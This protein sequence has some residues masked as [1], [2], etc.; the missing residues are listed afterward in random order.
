LHTAA[1]KKP[2]I[3]V[4]AD[5]LLPPHGTFI[6]CQAEALEGFI[7]YY[8]GPRQLVN[9]GLSLPAERVLAINAA[10]GIIGKIRETPFR[11]FG[12]APIY[13][14]RLRSLNPVLL[15]AHFG[16]AGL[17]ALCLAE[18]L[19]IPLVTTFHGFD[20]TIED[21][22]LT[23]SVFKQARYV[24]RRHILGRRGRLFL[25]VSQFI[26]RKMLERGFSEKKIVVHYTG[27]DTDFF[28][29]DQVV[30][31]EP[32]VL[33]TG[34]LNQQKGCEYLI[35]AMARV[36]AAMPD[37]ELVVIGEGP[38]RQRLEA[39]AREKLTRFRFLGTQNPNTVRH[40]MNRAKVFSVPSVAAES[41]AEEGFGMVF[42][43][44]QAMGCP[45][46][47]F[48]TGGIPEAVAHEQ[49]GL[50]AKERDAETLSE[51]ILLLLGNEALWRQMSAA[52]RNRVCALFDLK[53]QTKRLEDIYDQVTNQGQGSPP[54]LSASYAL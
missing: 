6:R 42:A 52:G 35:Q 5:P 34:S 30:E 12:Y 47:S 3:L 4:F 13:F 21:G 49:T 48:S 40:W 25:A 46:V 1:K 24:R 27:V 44:A 54:H 14:R 8:I 37:I 26:K 31:R 11:W 51:F 9:R 38:L 50:L 39:L 19:H 10:D 43:E 7:P 23:T 18:W 36:Q 32:I 20:A 33:F 29:V 45:V 16:P 22:F 2:T 17:R 28:R 41:G 15:H 53:T